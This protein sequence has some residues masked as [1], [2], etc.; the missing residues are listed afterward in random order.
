MTHTSVIVR[1]N[2]DARTGKRV[3]INVRDL[4]AFGVALGLDPGVFVNRAQDAVNRGDFGALPSFTT[5]SQRTGRASSEERGRLAGLDLPKVKDE[6]PHAEDT[7][8]GGEADTE[9]GS[10]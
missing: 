3:P 6:G 1:M 9:E 5:Q 2:G 8:T 4:Y 10:A 7:D